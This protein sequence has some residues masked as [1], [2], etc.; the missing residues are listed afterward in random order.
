MRTRLGLQE[1]IILTRQIGAALKMKLPLHG[2]FESESV[3]A[4]GRIRPILSDLAR[5]LAKG[6]RLSLALSRYP[7]YFPKYYRDAVDAGEK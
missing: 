5:D 1:L 7:R 2:A 6:E 4:P 3:Q